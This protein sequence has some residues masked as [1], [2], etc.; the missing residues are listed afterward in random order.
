M[1]VEFDVPDLEAHILDHRH[2]A[3]AGRIA[4]AEVAVDI[5]LGETGILQRTL[6]HFGVDLCQGQV[7]GQSRWMLIDTGNI[8]FALDAH[9]RG[10]S[11]FLLHCIVAEEP[12]TEKRP[13][14]P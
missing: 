12:L 5:V 11:S 2:R 3:E 4:G 6:G 1:S 7:L 8:R 14:S 13:L 9:R 10:F